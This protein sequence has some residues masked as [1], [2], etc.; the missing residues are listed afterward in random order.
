[1][2]CGYLGEINPRLCIE[3]I[4]GQETRRNVTGFGNGKFY[5]DD[6]L[7]NYSEFVIL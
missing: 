7:N 2:K 6:A 5:G 4:I 1:L 3:P